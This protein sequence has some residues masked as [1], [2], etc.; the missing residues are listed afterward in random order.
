MA[1]SDHKIVF[2][3]MFLSPSIMNKLDQIGSLLTLVKISSLNIRDEKWA[4]NPLKMDG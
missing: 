2:F 1:I 3:T 4:T